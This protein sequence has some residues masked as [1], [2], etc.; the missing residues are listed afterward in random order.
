M[1]IY[2]LVRRW[3]ACVLLCVLI[4]AVFPVLVRA[5]EP[6]SWMEAQDLP[7]LVSQLDDWLDRQSGYPRRTKPP[8]IRSIDLD[9]AL[10]LSGAMS[11][12][13]AL[14]PRGFYDPGTKEIMLVRPWSPRN[15]HDV[16]VLL[17]ELVHHRQAANEHWYCPGAQELPAYKLQRQWLAELGLKLQANWIAIF[18]ESGCSKSDIHPD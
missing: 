12:S 4:S 5:G 3:L 7:E 6:S 9:D 15:A 13:G 8:A 18:L 2:V 16:S 11:S 10:A 14:R 17:H 1:A